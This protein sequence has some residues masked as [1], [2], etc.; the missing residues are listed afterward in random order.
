MRNGIIPLRASRKVIDEV[1]KNDMLNEAIM[2]LAV[3]VVVTGINPACVWFLVR[4]MYEKEE[5]NAAMECCEGI[6]K[7]L[8]PK[9]IYFSE[10]QTFEIHIEFAKAL[11][12]A[13]SD[14]IFKHGIIEDY[15]R[16]HIVFYL[17][18]KRHEVTFTT[19]RHIEIDRFP[20]DPVKVCIPVDA[21]IKLAV[22][23]IM[24]EGGK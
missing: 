11:R 15:D 16:P 22:S 19:R 10:F 4:A 21:N 7:I 9:N 6:L 20:G 14:A 8:N 1:E 2:S 5:F 13:S 12:E 17:A 3:D 24:N 23:M 18:E